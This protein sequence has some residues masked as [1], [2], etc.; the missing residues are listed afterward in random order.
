M[1]WPCSPSGRLERAVCCGGSVSCTRIDGVIAATAAMLGY[2][3]MTAQPVVQYASLTDVGMRRSANQDSLAVRLCKE[4]SEW[5]EMGHLFVV[6]DG[7]GGHSVGDLASSITVETLPLAFTKSD[8]ET[9]SGRLK[10][11]FDAAKRAIGDKARENP[12]FA[13]MGTTCS[14]LSLSGSGAWIGHVGDSRVYRIRDA[15][16]EQLTFD[17]SLQW[18]MIRQGRATAESSELLHPRNVITRCLGPDR[19]VEI[20]I[21]GPFDVRTGDRFVLCSDGLTGHV[22]DS[23]IGAIVDV[24]PAGEASRLL[25]DLANCRGGSDNTT[26]VIAVVDEY[27]PITAP[28]VESHTVQVTETE[29]DAVPMTRQIQ[30]ERQ[31]K[32]S[33]HVTVLAGVLAF[34]G[35]VLLINQHQSPGLILVCGALILGFF[36]LSMSIRKSTTAQANGVNRTAE[37]ARLGVREPVEFSPYRRESAELG[38]AF[39]DL[40]TQAHDELSMAAADKNWEL[41]TAKLTQL[42]QKASATDKDCTSGSELLEYAAVL[43]ILMKEFTGRTR[44]SE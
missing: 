42:A 20:D 13:D 25:I 4:Y 10:E 15:V 11:A 30:T 2:N 23:E 41:D 26:V 44:V 35:L 29:D 39:L 36:Q 27:P 6:A 22:T 17:H 8:A 1:C 9:P 32:R 24:L 12:E 19:N 18:E 14:T 33:R 31:T 34:T 37:P 3:D 16:I 40:Q 5:A 38:A 21:E 7:M 43:R 28:T